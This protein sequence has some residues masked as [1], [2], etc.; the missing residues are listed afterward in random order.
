VP[1]TGSP[2]ADETTASLAREQGVDWASAAKDGTSSKTMATAPETNGHRILPNK[3]RPQ[4]GARND[5]L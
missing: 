1:W 2:S 3:G 5:R 4:F